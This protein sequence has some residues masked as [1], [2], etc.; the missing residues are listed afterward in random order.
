M[1]VKACSYD[2]SGLCGDPTNRES[3]EIVEMAYT[4]GAMRFSRLDS[5]VKNITF[6]TK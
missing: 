4:N 5:T 3:N 1:A 2:K 6:N